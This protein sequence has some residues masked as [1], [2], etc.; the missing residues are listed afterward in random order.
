LTPDG[1]RLD[2]PLILFDHV[3]SDGI[4]ESRCRQDGK[5][6]LPESFKDGFVWIARMVPQHRAQIG[7]KKRE[8]SARSATSAEAHVQGMCDQ[9]DRRVVSNKHDQG[10]PFDCDI[11][12]QTM[13]CRGLGEK[14]TCRG[15]RFHKERQLQKSWASGSD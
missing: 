7:E 3:S 11:L 13:S 8:G 10:M 15:K 4:A 9:H 5:G 2:T 12:L 14:S 1:P 6:A